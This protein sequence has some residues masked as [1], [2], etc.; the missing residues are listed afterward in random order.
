M[1]DSI[2]D[3]IK[4]MLGVDPEYDAFDIDIITHINSAFMML[5][6]IGVGPSTPFSISDNSTMWDS[7]IQDVTKF[8]T[9]K[10][11]VYFRVKLAFDP[12]SS[13]FVLDSMKEQL[14]E[15]EWRLNMQSEEFIK[16]GS[17]NA[18]G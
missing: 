17:E 1:T 6:Q 2:L 5:Y 12:P 3:T 4:K 11:Y 8:Q 10:S 13:S 7:F 18:Q 16:E 15:A 14:R 9:V